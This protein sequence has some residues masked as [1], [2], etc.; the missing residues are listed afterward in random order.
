MALDGEYKS[1]NKRMEKYL[2]TLSLS[3]SFSFHISFSSSPCLALL[4]QVSHCPVHGPS[5][6]VLNR[7]GILIFNQCYCYRDEAAIGFPFFEGREKKMEMERIRKFVSGCFAGF[8]AVFDEPISFRSKF[9]SLR[10]ER[11]EKLLKNIILISRVKFS[12]KGREFTTR[13]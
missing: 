1:R 11:V 8:H 2:G 9:Y 12:Y 13:Y 10:I 4:F 5:Q 7:R 3:L 6:V